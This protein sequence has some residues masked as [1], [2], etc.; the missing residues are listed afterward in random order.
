MKTYK[1]EGI[2]FTAS[3]KK[4]AVKDFFNSHFETFMCVYHLSFNTVYKRAFRTFTH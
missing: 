2:L 4:Q 1:V 3:T